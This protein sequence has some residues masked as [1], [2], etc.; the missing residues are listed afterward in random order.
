MM[1]APRCL[2][3]NSPAVTVR[4]VDT[5]GTPGFAFCARCLAD[6]DAGEY[7]MLAYRMVTAHDDLSLRQQGIW[8]RVYADLAKAMERRAVAP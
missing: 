3:C 2:C 7:R 4:V 5:P 6:L 8:E 1:T